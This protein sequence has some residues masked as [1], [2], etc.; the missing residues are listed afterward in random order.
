MSDSENLSGDRVGA[1]NDTNGDRN[2][3]KVRFKDVG[4]DSTKNILVDIHLVSG[5]SWNDKLLGGRG[6]RPSDGATDMDLEIED[7]DILRSIFNGIPTL[8]FS[9][10]LKKILV[11]DME[12]TVVVKLLGCNIGYGV[13]HNRISNLWRPSQ[14]FRLMDVENGYYLI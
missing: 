7:G 10:R 5:V 13:L 2:T 9:E 8:D 12:S 4:K 11:K 14:P 3:K 1:E 6:S